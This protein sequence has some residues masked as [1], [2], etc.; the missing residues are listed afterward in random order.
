MVRSWM[1]LDSLRLAR[2]SDV[3]IEADIVQGLRGS[4]DA[5][6]DGVFV[7]GSSDANAVV[8]CCL[9]A[10][11]AGVDVGERAP[12]AFGAGVSA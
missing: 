8:R 5:R 6:F 1:R 3:H 9:D 10:G 11:I 4:H 2:L 7:S 12:T